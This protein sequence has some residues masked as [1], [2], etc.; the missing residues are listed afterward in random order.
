MKTARPCGTICKSLRQRNPWYWELSREQRYL[1]EQS[2]SVWA[3]KHKCR[4]IT[5]QGL[6][7]KLASISP[8]ANRVPGALVQRL[9]SYNGH[10]IRIVSNPCH[11]CRT[12]AH[13]NST[14]SSISQADVETKQYI[15]M[16]K[17]FDVGRIPR[18]SHV[19]RSN[20]LTGKS[21][22]KNLG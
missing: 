22:V 11:F 10:P 12:G 4:I 2:R 5:H 6:Q 9:R 17:G 15:E 21:S 8:E 7:G 3:M 13:D 16:P 20:K 18:A 19:L 1:E 14:L